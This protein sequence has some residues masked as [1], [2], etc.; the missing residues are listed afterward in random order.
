[1]SHVQNIGYERLA[2]KAINL[3]QARIEKDFG[4]RIVC[5]A[6]LEFGEGLELCGESKFSKMVIPK[7][8]RFD[9]DSYRPL[10]DRVKDGICKSQCR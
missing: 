5:G 10:R 8:M 7:P 4:L 6:E 2:I 3:L 9:D 1:M